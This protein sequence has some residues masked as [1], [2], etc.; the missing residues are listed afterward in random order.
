[1]SIN[2]EKLLLSNAPEPRQIDALARVG[3]G[4]A[5]KREQ[6]KSLSSSKRAHYHVDELDL[7]D[8]SESGDILQVR[9]RLAGRVGV[10][11]DYENSSRPIWSYKLFDTRWIYNGEQWVASRALYKFEHNRVDTLMAERAIRVI[12]LNPVYG[13]DADG[14]TVD[15]LEHLLIQDDEAAF[16][17]LRQDFEAVSSDDCNE[18]MRSL[19][20]YVQSVKVLNEI[21]T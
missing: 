3:V 10:R 14:L 8:T 20:S 21:Q 13:H 17:G 19:Q 18:L 11:K 4:F 7:C 2:H 16:M 12:G 1:M 6:L 5:A 15:H 9:H